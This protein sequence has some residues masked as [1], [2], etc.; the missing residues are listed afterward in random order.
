MSFIVKTHLD[1]WKNKATQDNLVL[2][3][4]LELIFGVPYFLPM[5]KAVQTL[6]KFV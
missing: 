3:D 5:L 4:N 6:T 1:S 2:I